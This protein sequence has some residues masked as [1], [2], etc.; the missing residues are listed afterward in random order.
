M[1]GNYYHWYKEHGI[2]VNC[3]KRDAVPGYV[4]CDG[5]LELKRTENRKRRESAKEQETLQAYRKRHRKERLEQGLC[6]RCGKPLY[7][8]HKLCYECVLENRRRAKQHRENNPS[9]L[10]SGWK[11]AGLCLRCGKP[12][13]KDKM[14]CEWHYQNALQNI[15]KARVASG[16]SG[17]YFHK[18][19]FTG[20]Y[21]G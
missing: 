11:K 5:C 18:K 15:E 17:N 14:L 13:A 20:R 3:G 8:G 6:P 9:T 16:W 2:C 19:Y 21:P 10:K 1:Q 4:M 7:A 12:R